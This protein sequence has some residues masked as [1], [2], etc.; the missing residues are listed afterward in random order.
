MR[1]V[2]GLI[3]IGITLLIGFGCEEDNMKPNM[4]ALR[5]SKVAGNIAMEYPWYKFEYNQDGMVEKFYRNWNPEGSNQPT[6]IVYNNKNQPIKVHN[7]VIE[8]GDN[9]FT[10]KSFWQNELE[11]ERIY[12]LDNQ[13]RILKIT[14]TDFYHNITSITDMKWI[15]SDSLYIGDRLDVINGDTTYYPI[16]HSFKFNDFNHP[17]SSINLAVI[18]SADMALGE[19]DVEYQNKYCI[20]KFVEGNNNTYNLYYTLNEKRYPTRMEHFQYVYFEYED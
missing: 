1:K 20:E 14:D 4:N 15:G 19:W 2:F 13:G 18:I 16:N 17:L 3:L 7:Q 8:W 11:R 9:E 10:I 6:L 12:K 5:I